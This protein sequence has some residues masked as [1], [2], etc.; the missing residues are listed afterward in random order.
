MPLTFSVLSEPSVFRFFL[1][2]FFG[3]NEHLD[4]PDGSDDDDDLLPSCG[5]AWHLT[6]V[7]ILV[8]FK[9]NVFAT[10]NGPANVRLKALEILVAN[11]PV[12]AEF[13]HGDFPRLS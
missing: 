1:S 3:T 9:A 11:D 10:S 2:R 13:S 8:M 12:V 6:T 5:C 4:H 7:E